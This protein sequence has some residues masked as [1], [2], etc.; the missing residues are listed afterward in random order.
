M[1]IDG[2]FVGGPCD[3]SV[4]KAVV[5]S[6]FDGRTVGSVAE[7]DGTHMNAALAAAADA[8]PGWRR[9]GRAERQALLARIAGEIRARREELA[10][11]L[12]LEIGKPV[13]LA[14]GEVDR[15]AVTF[16]LSAGLLDRPARIAVDPGPDSRAPKYDVAYKRMPIGVVLAISPYNWPYNLSAH[17]IAPALA[18]GNTVVL[19]GSGSSSL[20]ALTLARI[21][22]E[23]GCPPGVFNAVNVSGKVAGEAALDPRVAMVSFTGSPAVG[24]KLKDSAPRKRIA[25]E[26][27]GTACVLVD[28]SADL[29]AAAQRTAQAAYAYAGQICISAQHTL[30]D[31]SVSESFRQLLV[32]AVRAV[33]YGDPADP[34][35]V[36]GPLIHGA[37][38][39]GVDER[40]QQAIRSGASQLVGGH[41]VGNVIPPTLLELPAGWWG[42]SPELF[43]I[44]CEEIFGPVLTFS[45]YDSLDEA[46]ARVNGLP[47][48]L[49][50]ALFSNDQSVIDRVEQEIEVG[51]LVVNDGPTVRF[52]AMPYGGVRESGVG[53]EGPAF[54]AEEMTDPRA[55]VRRKD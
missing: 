35:V 26:L 3:T 6:P 42:N 51:G 46:I 14:L 48:G 47:L 38:T 32:D 41:M 18:V 53:R 15:M 34:E 28:A 7:G 36:S 2:H 5:K 49:Q 25:L 50:S 40:I 52:D 45:T 21:I 12:V 16:E 39:R 11:V 24:W 37:A 29:E 43:P 1:L 10:E 27:G 33:K 30:V 22:H 31:Q 19:K 54:V 4:P 8:F 17:K 44:I 20:S 23:C 9:T 55:F 13:T